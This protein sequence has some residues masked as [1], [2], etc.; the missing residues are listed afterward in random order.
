MPGSVIIGMTSMNCGHRQYGAFRIV[1]IKRFWADTILGW[2]WVQWLQLHGAKFSCHCKPETTCL[3]Q[4]A[5][6]QNK[7]GKPAKA[8]ATRRLSCAKVRA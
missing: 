5:L 4:Q 3:R 2:K 7:S 1:F 8:N 6:Q